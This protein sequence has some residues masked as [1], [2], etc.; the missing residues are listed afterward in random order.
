MKYPSQEELLRLFEYRDG[1]LIRKVGGPG[2]RVGGCGG[3]A[4]WERISTD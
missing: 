3:D 1:D 2:C 4:H